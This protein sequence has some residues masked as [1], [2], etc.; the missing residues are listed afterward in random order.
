[1]STQSQ[2]PTPTTM[3][4]SVIDDD[5]IHLDES[6][7]QN[8]P[9]IGV[10]QRDLVE[11]PVAR[12]NRNIVD[13][14]PSGFL[15]PQR[16]S[17]EMADFL[18]VPHRTKMART[19]VSKCIHKYIERH[20]LQNPRNGREIIPDNTLAQLLNYSYKGDDPNEKLSYFNLQ[21]HMKHHFGRV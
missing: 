19:A 18:D 16:I 3:N 2:S 20:N 6:C 1:M 15:R 7:Y 4:M 21:K 9:S 17:D 12:N 8:I 11:Q 10:E 14:R 13:R 5:I